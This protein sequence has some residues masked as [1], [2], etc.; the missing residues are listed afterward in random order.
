MES[1]CAGS[2]FILQSPLKSL[3]SSAIIPDDAKDD[4]LHFAEK[5]QKHFEEFIQNRL[6]TTSTLSAWDPI[7][8]LKLRPQI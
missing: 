8:S 2:P 6:L 1:H 3:V 7:K 4:I 5:I